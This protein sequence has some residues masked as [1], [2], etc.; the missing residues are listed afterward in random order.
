MLALVPPWATGLSYYVVRSTNTVGSLNTLMS[1]GLC[2]LRAS[3]TPFL[4]QG[5]LDVWERLAHATGA[6]L[7]PL[8]QPVADRS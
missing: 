8:P 2:V 5:L 1:I 6:G 7:V 3:T 4:V